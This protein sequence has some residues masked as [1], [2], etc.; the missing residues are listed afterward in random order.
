VED[1]SGATV[2]HP[3]EPSAAAFVWPR[4]GRY[5]LFPGALAHGVLPCDAARSAEVAAAAAEAGGSPDDGVRFT[6]L[7]NWCVAL[8][9]IVALH[10]P[11]RAR[12]RPRHYAS[13]GRANAR[14]ASRR[15]KTAPAAPECAPFEPAPRLAQAARAA[16]AA[17]AR[18]AGAPRVERVEPSRGAQPDQCLLAA[19]ESAL[20]G[21]LSLRRRVPC[22]EAPPPASSPGVL[23]VRWGGAHGKGR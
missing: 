16:R 4:A 22:P 13:L 3:A 18:R 9:R 23:G 1:V 17:A 2:A 12:P 11:R 20:G 10:T 6:M 14:R 8:H 21:V 15:W 7:V 5:A 19:C